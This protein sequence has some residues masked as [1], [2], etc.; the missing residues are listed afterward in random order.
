M[1]RIITI[2]FFT[3]STTLLYSQQYPEYAIGVKGGVTAS[4]I[5][6]DPTIPQ[7]I[8]PITFHSG[9]HFRMISEKY[10]GFIIELNY[11]QR[12]FSIYENNTYTHRRLDYIELPFLTHVT[13][14]KKLCRFFFNVG[15]S[16]AYMIN[17]VPNSLSIAEAH[18][19]PVN[20]FDYGIIGDIG[21]EFN[22]TYGI[23][24]FNLRYNFGLSNIFPSAGSNYYN[25]SSNQNI[26]ASI[27]YLFP[28]R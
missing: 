22:T 13:F 11:I 2:I 18:T 1:K 6:A 15:P 10:F 8:P 20:K 23:Y 21:M 3:I 16:I 4:L 27:A 25:M 24:M 14:G 28:L 12:G 9:A 19:I 7:N 26:S 17:D 5:N